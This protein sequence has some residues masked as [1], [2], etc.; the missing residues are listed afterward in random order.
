MPTPEQERL[1]AI[2]NSVAQL[3]R[4]QDE[5]AER[6]ARIEA[7]V[8]P[9]QAA[10]TMAEEPLPPAPSFIRSDQAAPP[11]TAPSPSRTARAERPRL[12]TKV[13]LTIINRVGVVTLVLGIAFFFKWAVD[14]N[15]IGPGGRVV[16]GVIASFA[17]LGAADF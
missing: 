7:A 4:R 13:G 3:W 6:L 5:F 14:N 15:W 12:E 9:Q 1:D 16:L 2:A 11:A 17:A 8:L 10:P